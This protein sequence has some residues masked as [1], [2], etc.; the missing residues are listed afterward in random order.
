ME[1]GKGWLSGL[2]P[3]QFLVFFV[4]FASGGI[5]LAGMTAF[6]GPFTVLDQSWRSIAVVAMVIGFAGLAGLFAQWAAE[7]ANAIR[8]K[9]R[10]K[11]AARA[12]TAREAAAL[13]AE[14]LANLPVLSR[15]ESYA[16]AW[17]LCRASPRFE[18]EIDEETIGDLVRKHIVRPT[19]TPDVLAVAG[20][21]WERRED[22]LRALTP[23]EREA[24]AGADAPWR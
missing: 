2:R 5:V 10:S 8:R 11:A 7:R 21:V 15:A 14:A 1:A 6:V 22:I 3:S 9:R 18:A 4:L 17:L 23:Q 24:M 13:D 16:L 20:S 12:E 19:P